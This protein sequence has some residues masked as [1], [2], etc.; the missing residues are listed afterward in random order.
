MRVCASGGPAVDKEPLVKDAL[1]EKSDKLVDELQNTNTGDPLT[2][3]RNSRLI[4]HP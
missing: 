1:R 3:P 4:P 2:R